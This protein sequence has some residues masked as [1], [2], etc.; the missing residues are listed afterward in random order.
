MDEMLK[1]LQ[2]IE[3]LNAEEGNKSGFGTNWK[4]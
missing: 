1:D 2:E 3:K 4:N